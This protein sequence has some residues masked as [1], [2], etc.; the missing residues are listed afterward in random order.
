M[1]KDAW[2][3]PYIYFTA[4]YFRRLFWIDFSAKWAKSLNMTQ[5][6]TVINP[7]PEVA[8]AWSNSR[9]E[10]Q[11]EKSAFGL[12]F[13]AE[14]RQKETVQDRRCVH[15]GPFIHAVILRIN[16]NLDYSGANQ[17]RNVVIINIINIINIMTIYDHHQHN[18]DPVERHVRSV[19]GTKLASK[20]IFH[21][22]SPKKAGAVKAVGQRSW[23]ACSRCL[24]CL[25]KKYP[26]CVCVLRCPSPTHSILMN[27]WSIYEELID[28][29]SKARPWTGRR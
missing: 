17:T 7:N 8:V 15:S 27:V 28:S 9:A 18:H 13:D 6:V 16:E 14:S 19:S 1:I 25:L 4:N 22:L 23:P 10:L 24:S 2:G 11:A 26:G 5:L 21:P 12:G 29:H 20:N 3:T